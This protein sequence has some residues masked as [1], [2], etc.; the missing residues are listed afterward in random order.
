MSRDY[1]CDSDIKKNIKQAYTPNRDMEGYHKVKAFVAAVQRKS[2]LYRDDELRDYISRRYLGGQTESDFELFAHGLLYSD[3]DIIFNFGKRR[4][5]AFYTIISCNEK[6]NCEDIQKRVTC[7]GKAIF[8]HN[9][10]SNVIAYLIGFAR[11][12]SLTKL[13]KEVAGIVN[14][15]SFLKCRGLQTSKPKKTFWAKELEKVKL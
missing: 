2:R 14:F 3:A 10:P 8:R 5:S 13:K 4:D 15:V 7:L 12:N 1:G 11:D 9:I 6:L